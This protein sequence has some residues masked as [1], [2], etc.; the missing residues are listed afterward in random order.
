MHANYR[1]VNNQPYKTEESRDSN[2]SKQEQNPPGSSSEF[3][4]YVI[5]HQISQGD[6]KLY[7]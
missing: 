7:Y 1:G 3:S 6:N 4:L 5:V 2:S